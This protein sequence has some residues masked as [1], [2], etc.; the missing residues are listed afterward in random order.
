M[1]NRFKVDGNTGV[2]AIY[3]VPTVGSTD[4]DPFTDPLDHKDR[5][6][7]HSDLVYPARIA[8][9]AGSIVLP[10]RSSADIPPGWA[11]FAHQLDAHGQSGIPLVEGQVLGLSDHGGA[12]LPLVGSIP[13]QRIAANATVTGNW[14]WL[15]LA[16]DATYLWLHEGVQPIFSGFS[17]MPA[18]TVNY[19]IHIL[20]KVFTP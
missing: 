6:I 7:F 12:D 15:T 14:R 19:E 16:A 17:T 20:D 13:V 4:D 18:L 5:I 11:T 2:V 8:T 3:T 9:I 1:P 10:A